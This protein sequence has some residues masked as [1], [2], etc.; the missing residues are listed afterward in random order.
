MNSSYSTN[1]WKT[2]PV[3]FHKAP[4]AWIKWF[5]GIFRNIHQRATRGYCEYDLW[6]L[7]DYYAEMMANSLEHFAET[8][9]GYPNNY[10]ENP[11]KWVEDIK[12]ISISFRAWQ[13]DTTEEAW[14]K[15]WQRREK[16][17]AENPKATVKGLEIMDS[18]LLTLKRMAINTEVELEKAKYE[19][20]KNGFDKL[21]TIFPALWD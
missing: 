14:K 5:F 3:K 20:V 2:F 6:H 1:L 4:I 11:D 13:F 8:A 7:N 16:L 15:Y 18:E 10:A 17:E 21:K 19:R 12:D 9:Q